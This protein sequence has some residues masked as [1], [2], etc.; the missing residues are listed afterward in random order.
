MSGTPVGMVIGADDLCPEWLVGDMDDGVAVFLLKL[1]CLLSLVLPSTA[2]SL[3]SGSLS[4]FSD[5]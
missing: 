3:S 5:T 4:C 1:T 2:L